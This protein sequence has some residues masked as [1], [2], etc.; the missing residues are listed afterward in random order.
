MSSF[1]V[2]AAATEA[3]AHRIVSHDR[4][5]AMR[6][7]DRIAIGAGEGHVLLTRPEFGIPVISMPSATCGHEGR[8]TEHDAGLTDASHAAMSESTHA[9]D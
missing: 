8:R 5:T 7:H 1:D 4:R 6:L 2:S 9:V 3:Q